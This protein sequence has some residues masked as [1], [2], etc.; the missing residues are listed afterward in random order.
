[1]NTAI[2]LQ[3]LVVVC[4]A[5]VVVWIIDRFAPDPLLSNIGKLVVFIIVVFWVVTKL[6]PLIS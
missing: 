6:L 3:A 1:M 2:L 5:L 4:V